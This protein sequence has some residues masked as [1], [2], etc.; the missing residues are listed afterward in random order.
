MNCNASAGRMSRR[1]DLLRP[2]RRRMRPTRFMVEH[3][4]EVAAIDQR[5]AD[6]APIEMLRLLHV[7]RLAGLR[8]D[9]DALVFASLDHAYS[10]NLLRTPARPPANLAGALEASTATRDRRPS[11]RAPAAAARPRATV[12][13]QAA[14]SAPAASRTV[15]GIRP[16]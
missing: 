1:I 9:P 16:A 11:N 2:I 10:P 8:I 3:L 4:P 12:Y 6:L 15:R 14:P 5:A 13:A 7:E